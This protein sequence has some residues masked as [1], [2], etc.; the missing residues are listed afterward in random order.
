MQPSSTAA[1]WP[2]RSDGRGEDVSIRENPSVG[3]E[4]AATLRGVSV[5]EYEVESSE[6]ASIEKFENTPLT[7]SFL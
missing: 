3:T 2:Y 6:W 4:S 7:D 1:E 5:V